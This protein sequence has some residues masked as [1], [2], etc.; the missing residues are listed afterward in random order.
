MTSNHQADIGVGIIGCGYWGPNLIRNFN[1]HPRCRVER[2]ADMRRSPA[3]VAGTVTAAG[4]PYF[5][6]G[7]QN[8]GT[9]TCYP[10]PFAERDNNPNM[11]KG[12]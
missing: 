2:V 8:V 11:K 7:Y 12:S 3:S 4:Q 1:R 10:L 9:N 6:P 5:K